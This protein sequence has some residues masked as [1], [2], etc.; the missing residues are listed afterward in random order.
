MAHAQLARIPLH[1]RSAQ[2]A[3]TTRLVHTARLVN[4]E[5]GRADMLTVH[6][7]RRLHA[8][9]RHHTE[10]LTFCGQGP[11]S[12][13]PTK[14]WKQNAE[15]LQSQFLRY[16]NFKHVDR[17]CSLKRLKLDEALRRRGAAKQETHMHVCRAAGC[18][19]HLEG[20]GG[21]GGHGQRGGREASRE[22]T[23]RRRRR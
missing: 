12:C 20:W 1:V 22:T 5:S 19:V 13:K 6:I 3:N 8:R 23:S 10:S 14:Q 11:A 15:P 18:G 2:C 4:P 16:A 7:Q 21:S 9:I 17:F